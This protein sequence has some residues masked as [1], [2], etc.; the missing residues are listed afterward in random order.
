V[1]SDRE[2]ELIGLSDLELLRRTYALVERV[3]DL[4]AHLEDDFYCY[5]TE[6]FERFAPDV[7]RVYVDGLHVGEPKELE[8]WRRSSRE[9]EGARLI[10]RAL[11]PR[12]GREQTLRHSFPSPERSFRRPADHR[13]RQT[14]ARRGSS[15]QRAG[16]TPWR[17]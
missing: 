5:L 16:K 17:A 10:R 6:A 4:D 15:W 12:K 11:E 14:D 7:E 13:G 9:R 3:S 1:I 8:A 2:T